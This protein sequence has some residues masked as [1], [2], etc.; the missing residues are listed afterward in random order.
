MKADGKPAIRW[1]DARKHTI[2]GQDWK[3]TQKNRLTTRID[4]KPSFGEDGEAT[5]EGMHA[6]DLGFLRIAESLAPVIE[7]ALSSKVTASHS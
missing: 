7:I 1:I 6:A 3:G 4:S 2:E 5:V